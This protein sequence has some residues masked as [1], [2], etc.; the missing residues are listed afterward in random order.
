M[1]FESLALSPALLK[2]LSNQN[3]TAA[4]PIQEAAIPAILS[5]RDVLA[6][7]KT[8]SGKTISYVLPL[9]MNLAHLPEAKNRH[10]NALI[11]VPTRELAEQ[12]KAVLT[13]YT[14][15][16]DPALKTLAVYGGSSINPQ[17]IAMQ[18]VHILVATPGRLIEL[19]ASNAVHL[20]SIST[21]ILDEADKML[22]IG[23]QD[24]VNKI[25]ALLPKKRQNVLISATLSTDL[26][27]IKQVILNDPIVIK[28]E[29][30]V[31]PSADLI[32][33][34]AYLLA[35]EKKGPY[36]RELIKKH[37]MKQ[38][39]IFAS[40]TYQ[41]D[42]IV[43]K[44]RKNK[45]EARAI[46]SKKSQGSRNESLSL[47]KAG[48]LNVLVAT[49]LIARGIDIDNLP[50]VINYELPR[51]PKDYIHR[52]GRTGRAEHTGTAISL[53]TPNELHHFTVIQKKMGKEIQLIDIER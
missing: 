20:S 27:N 10:I 26:D 39:L 45:I 22:S 52:I 51:S 50:Y 4:T 35:E 8:G 29:T 12:V 37:D 33:Q 18:G 17:M 1:S 32:D 7:A 16:S 42:A 43:N 40:S 13:T 34:V 25:I 28:A 3:I 9:I 15:D 47:F 53:V 6:I 24:E 21:L 30:V 48:K 44:L 19:V 36:L 23:F 11:L 5:K 38:V 14:K 41:V 49:D 2:A 46:H 31:E